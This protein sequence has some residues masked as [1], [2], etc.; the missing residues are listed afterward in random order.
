MSRRRPTPETP[1]PALAHD[2]RLAQLAAE[3]FPAAQ[4][5]MSQSDRAAWW[6]GEYVKALRDLPHL[7]PSEL[8][9]LIKEQDEA[10]S[11][12]TFTRT[13]K[14]LAKPH[15]GG[16]TPA[17]PSPAPAARRKVPEPVQP[18][19]PSPRTDAARAEP[20]SAPPVQGRND[21]AGDADFLQR[22]TRLHATPPGEQQA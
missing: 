12:A 8:L 17:T 22:M 2:G 13:I 21:D 11:G 5:P 15:L 4:A 19:T 3:R 14:Q 1:L 18:A 10:A 7:K 16:R 9:A 20:P 6:L